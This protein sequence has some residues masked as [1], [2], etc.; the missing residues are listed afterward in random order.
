M[1]V[2]TVKGSPERKN[3]ILR[4]AE[5][6]FLKK[7]YAQA[8]LREICAKAE[9]TTGALYFYFK[10]KADLFD[11]LVRDVAIMLQ[12]LLEAQLYKYLEPE[13]SHTTIDVELIDYLLDNRI[14]ILLLGTKAKG[15]K[16]EGYMRRIEDQLVTSLQSMMENRCGRPVDRELAR[17]IMTMRV[18]AYETIISRPYTREEALDLFNN[19]L[20][21]GRAGMN[22]LLDSLMSE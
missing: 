14:P 19:I 20:I 3:A 2:S 13:H 1:E 11:T 4:C 10:S 22:C 7:G 6:E 15:T 5:E 16:Y 8:S 18:T 12:A 9:V 17:I 21:Y